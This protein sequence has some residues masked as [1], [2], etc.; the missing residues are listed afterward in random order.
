[1]SLAPSHEPLGRAPPV[2]GIIPYPDRDVNAGLDKLANVCY[3][4]PIGKREEDPGKADGG[5]KDC[6]VGLRLKE[7]LP[8]WN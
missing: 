1:M 4:D 8:P 7:E 3:N 6:N 2:R 5:S